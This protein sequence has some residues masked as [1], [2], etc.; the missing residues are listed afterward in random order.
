MVSS[1]SGVQSLSLSS[2]SGRT[3][4]RFIADSPDGND[5]MAI[6]SLIMTDTGERIAI[7]YGEAVDASEDDASSLIMSMR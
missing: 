2:T 3:T 7:T 4:T 6:P 5:A 1:A